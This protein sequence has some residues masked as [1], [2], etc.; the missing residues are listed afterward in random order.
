MGTLGP[1]LSGA[2][3]ATQVSGQNKAWQED[4]LPIITTAYG[5]VSFYLWIFRLCGSFH[6]R[7][8]MSFRVPRRA[9]LKFRMLV[10]TAL[11]DP[12]DSRCSQ[13]CFIHMEIIRSLSGAA[14]PLP[15]MPHAVTV[16]SAA[17]CHLGR[18]DLWACLWNHICHWKHAAEELVRHHR[19]M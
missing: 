10:S 14:G 9:V 3:T 4:V 2:I 6:S 17:S 18:R 16:W 1:S 12:E 11:H 15:H 13:W 7:D 19:E 8:Y 5:A